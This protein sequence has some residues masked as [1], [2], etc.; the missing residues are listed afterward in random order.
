MKLILL[1]SGKTDITLQSIGYNHVA[2]LV[3]F[4]V[5]FK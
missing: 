4:Y 1:T 2:Y 5:R 3:G